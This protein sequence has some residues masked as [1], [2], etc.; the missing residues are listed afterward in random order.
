MDPS[1]TDLQNG[2][3]SF[4]L[5]LLDSDETKSKMDSFKNRFL[6]NVRVLHEIINYSDSRAQDYQ[7]SA[8]SCSN[9]LEWELRFV[10]E[11]K[12]KIEATRRKLERH[13]SVEGRRECLK[14]MEEEMCRYEIRLLD[15]PLEFRY[16][17]RTAVTR[18]DIELPA[19]VKSNSRLQ[20][21]LS[22]DPNAKQAR[23]EE[24]RLN[25]ADELCSTITRRGDISCYPLNPGTKQGEPII[26]AGRKVPHGT[27]PESANFQSRATDMGELAAA[28]NCVDR[29]AGFGLLRVEYYFYHPESNQF[30]FAHTSPF[31]ASSMMTLE[32]MVTGDPFPNL[33]ISMGDRFRLAYKLAEAVIFLHTSGFHHK[34]ITSSSVVI[35]R[36]SDSK[37]EIDGS[38]LM[39]SDLIR[40][41][42]AWD[43]P[44]R[45]FWEFDVFQH[46][47][48]LQGQ[49][50]PSY[51]KTYDMY[52]LGVVLLEVGLWE[53]LS[54]VG[55]DWTIGD[56]SIWPNQL[57][58]SALKIPQRLGEEYYRLVAWCLSLKGNHVLKNGEFSDKVLDPL[59]CMVKANGG[60]VV[61]YTT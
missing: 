33:D 21:F 26:F 34:S 58:D 20:E 37:K 27:T 43:R 7:K 51:T 48:L 35:L 32:T 4:I 31:I 6:W 1:E 61:D 3:D 39:G 41:L 49:S 18:N 22:L 12:S 47:D 40:D 5:P 29:A 57:L 44:D 59:E 23:V 60:S 9:P 8:P 38:Y 2:A 24:M 36:R 10:D 52:S 14:E 45:S 46:P 56:S 42:E 53:P 16:I 13:I 11:F 50:S 17:I 30:L 28:F 25:S 15:L 54:V 19:I 55:R